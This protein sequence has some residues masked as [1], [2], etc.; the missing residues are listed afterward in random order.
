MPPK[1]IP[2]K[3]RISSLFK[4]FAGLSLGKLKA[5]Y[6]IWIFM[7]VML[8]AFSPSPLG[9][10]SLGERKFGSFYPFISNKD[11]NGER[12]GIF[13]DHNEQYD[14]TEFIFYSL[15][16]LVV[17]KSRRLWHESERDTV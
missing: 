10:K 9:A 12:S 5:I 6:L 4:G 2:K 3:S 7:H 8:L 13:V 14:I 11:Y 1:K 15:A 17:W 16:P